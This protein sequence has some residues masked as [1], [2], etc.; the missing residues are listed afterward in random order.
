MHARSRRRCLGRVLGLLVLL[1]C[2]CA[3]SFP[4]SAVAASQSLRPQQLRTQLQL[5]GGGTAPKTKK[6]KAGIA[7]STQ[8][9]LR[10]S[11]DE[12]EAED[13]GEAG[14]PDAVHMMKRV[15]AALKKPTVGKTQ[16]KGTKKDEEKQEC[17]EERGNT[18][19]DKHTLPSDAIM[20]GEMDDNNSANADAENRG[21]AEDEESENVDTMSEDS[22][23]D[24]EKSEK[25]GSTK[26]K[27]DT[28]KDVTQ[29]GADAEAAKRKEKRKRD[30][31]KKKG[32]L[33]ERKKEKVPFRH[34]IDK[35]KIL[36]SNIPMK[37]TI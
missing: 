10:P 11:L 16:K 18:R 35:V 37:I 27:I 4:G 1:H 34:W 13:A 20:E 17:A 14:D 2:T 6:A 5:R 33:K 25:R 3:R 19:D 31:L 21:D 9:E 22:D 12:E 32:R 36:S 24:T 15:K 23:G 28:K 30:K 26:M 8:L 7:I 29:G